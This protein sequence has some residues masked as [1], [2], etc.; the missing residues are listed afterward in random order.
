MT[1]QFGSRSSSFEW[2]TFVRPF[3]Q[4]PSTFV[5]F[6]P[7]HL[8]ILREWI[9]NRLFFISVVELAT[10][11]LGKEPADTESMAT[12]MLAAKVV[13]WWEHFYNESCSRVG[14][15][16]SVWSPV[17][18][19]GGCLV[20]WCRKIASWLLWWNTR[21]KIRPQDGIKIKLQS[22]VGT[23]TGKIIQILI[24]KKA[25][26]WRFSLRIYLILNCTCNKLK[27]RTS[28]WFQT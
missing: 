15:F 25:D 2:V 10:N 23:L 17:G 12:R 7:I 11:A 27:P 16:W 13:W 1:I 26:I 28:D 14:A 8:H 5:P 19:S 20:H 9:W 24:K 4:G 18:F 21:E 22:T 6:S 3:I